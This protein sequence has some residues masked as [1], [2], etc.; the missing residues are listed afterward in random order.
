[1]VNAFWF[2]SGCK[3]SQIIARSGIAVMKLVT[4][5]A[6]MAVHLRQLEGFA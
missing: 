6:A 3:L 5:A 4:A 2:L 1:M